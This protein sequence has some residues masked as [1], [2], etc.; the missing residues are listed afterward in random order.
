MNVNRTPKV[1]VTHSSIWT[2]TKHCPLVSS[3][4]SPHSSLSF[5][6]SSLS[7]SSSPTALIPLPFTPLLPLLPQ[8]IPLL[9]PSRLSQNFC[10]SNIAARYCSPPSLHRDIVPSYAF[11]LTH[12]ISS[13]VTAA[14]HR[15]ISFDSIMPRGQYDHLSFLCTHT[16]A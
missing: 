1:R 6:F 9:P 4:K 7:L 14:S 3:I 8:A 13:Q 2:L 11:V 10:S 5:C 12:F 16:D 15:I